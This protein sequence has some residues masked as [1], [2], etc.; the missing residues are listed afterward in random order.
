MYIGPP[1][2]L[3][4]KALLPG[5]VGSLVEDLGDGWWTVKFKA[6]GRTKIPRKHLSVDPGSIGQASE[7]W[8]LKLRMNKDKEQIDAQMIESL[9]ADYERRWLMGDIPVPAGEYEADTRFGES[10]R[11]RFLNL[12]ADGMCFGV[13]FVEVGKLVSLKGSWSSSPDGTVTLTWARDRS[14]HKCADIDFELLPELQRAHRLPPLFT[15][16]ASGAWYFQLQL[17]WRP[18]TTQEN[19]KDSVLIGRCLPFLMGRR[20]LQ[21]A[22]DEVHGQSMSIVC[23]SMAGK[24]V[25]RLQGLSSSTTLDELLAKVAIDGELASDALEL[26]FPNATSS[27]NLPR[28]TP[29]CD[30][31]QPV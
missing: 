31:L 25:K 24:E 16:Q 21:V 23:T 7:A 4:G 18:E 14:A 13:C 10:T 17:R 27:C 20:Y 9:R 29:L 2:R 28:D 19:N 5:F 11:S 15:R 8:A 26:V 30:L 12:R 6:R 1:D 3:A 22:L